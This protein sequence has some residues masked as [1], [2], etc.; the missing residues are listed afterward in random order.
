MCESDLHFTSHDPHF[1][2]SDQRNACRNEA[3]DFPCV[4]NKHNEG[5]N[6]NQNLQPDWPQYTRV[7]AN[8]MEMSFIL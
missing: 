7:K 4:G 3:A 2:Y 5:Y 8:V 6:M 1:H